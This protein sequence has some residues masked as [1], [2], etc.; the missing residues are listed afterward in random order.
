MELN[1]CNTTWISCRGPYRI[2]LRAH[3]ISTESTEA[4]APSIWSCVMTFTRFLLPAM[5]LLA[6]ASTAFG[7]TYSDPLAYCKAVG[8]IDK[9]DARYTGPKLP[10]WMAKQLKMQPD[11]GKMMEWRCADGA[12][13]ACQYGANIPCDAKAV[14]SQNPPQPVTDYCR[15]NPDSQFVPMY[16]TGHN[17]AV[18]WA[19]HGP[20]PVV[21]Q[22]AP[23]DAQGYQQAYWHKVEP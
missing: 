3:L 17:S 1:P 4:A 8:T 9:P 12:V 20:K 23:V 2:R 13:M 16:V 11:Q 14:T 15:Q 7:Q 19:C 18:S 10:A 5:I 6:F 22:S 21:L